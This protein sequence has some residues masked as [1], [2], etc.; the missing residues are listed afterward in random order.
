MGCFPFTPL[1]AYSLA[2]LL[3]PS[4]SLVRAFTYVPP[5]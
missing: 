1:V 5:G 4:V 2:A 3:T